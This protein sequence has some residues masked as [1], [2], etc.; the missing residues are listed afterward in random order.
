MLLSRCM[1]EF[2]PEMA[3]A[4]LAIT[5]YTN[6]VTSSNPNSLDAGLKPNVAPSSRSPSANFE[7]IIG[8]PR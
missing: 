1:E 3:P 4:K 2:K 7:I 5:R 8:H 6:D